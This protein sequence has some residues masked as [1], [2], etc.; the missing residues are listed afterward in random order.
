MKKVIIRKILAQNKMISFSLVA[1]ASSIVST[2]NTDSDS[3]GG[4]NSTTS[5]HEQIRYEAEESYM[6]PI[7][8]RQQGYNEKIKL[9]QYQVGDLV[10]RKTDKVDR[11]N[12]TPKI[13]PCKVISIESLSDNATTYRLCTTKCILSSKYCG[14]DLIDLTKCNFAELRSIDSQT[15]PTQTFIQA[16][17]AYVSKGT[18]LVVDACTCDGNCA[19]K[20][21][22]AKQQKYN[23][24]RSVLQAR[25]NPVRT[26]SC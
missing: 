6:Q 11:T 1:C 23:V 26:S 9:R 19:T 7:S 24:V 4:Y 20:N 25:K 18:D 22:H 14:L 16:C 10:G 21:A 8:K 15:L 5:R 3:T 13:L 2:N 12:T 17:K